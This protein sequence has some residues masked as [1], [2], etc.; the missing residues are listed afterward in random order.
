M[1]ISDPHLWS[2]IR[3]WPLP[4][5]NEVDYGANP[6]RVCTSFEDF[7]RKNGDWTD[8]SAVRITT[9][10]RQFLYLKALSG[11]PVT[12]S[13]T[14]DCAWHQHLQFPADYSALCAA[15]GRDIP[16]RKD[17]PSSKRKAAYERGR[18]LWKQEFGAEPPD[19]L[20]PS[21]EMRKFQLIGGFVASTG[22]LMV[23]VGIVVAVLRDEP[24]IWFVLGIV[25]FIGGIVIVGKTQPDT[26]SRCG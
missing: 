14:I 19:D 16:H 13:Y 17:L 24:S 6:P 18:E 1:P 21:P 22:I 8:R 3:D 5:R 2:V 7:L 15:V 20:W 12:P 25:F 11:E 4:F 26:V 9:M 23:I 10:Y